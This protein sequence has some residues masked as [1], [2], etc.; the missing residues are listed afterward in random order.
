[1]PSSRVVR[2]SLGPVAKRFKYHLERGRRLP[3]TGVIEIISIERLAPFV[4][5]TTKGPVRKVIEKMIL[6]HE[7]NAMSGT[8]RC[9][10]ESRFVEHQLNLGL[11]PQLLTA[12][13]K[14]SSV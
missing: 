11:D 7:R 14:F 6:D 5:H 8:R 12:V 13:L 9:Y 3:A 1:M 4:E 10:D 2:T